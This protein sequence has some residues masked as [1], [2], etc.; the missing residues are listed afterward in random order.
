ME[1]PNN[2]PGE[3]VSDSF[4][5]RPIGYVQSAYAKTK[6]VAHTRNAWTADVSQ[7]KLL[8]KYAKG[9]NG[10]EG[11]SHVIVLFWVHRAEEWKMPEGHGKPPNVKV[12]ATRMPVRPNPMGL[13]VV[14]LVEVSADSGVVVVKGLDALDETPVL[15][16]KP[17]LPTFDSC[18]EACVPQWVERHL[19]S[20]RKSCRECREDDDSRGGK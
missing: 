11:H 20:N 9:L 19:N 7:I 12:F 2:G 16:I 18:P 13:S 5:L 4:E 10:L 1:N 8:P 3:N 14:E 15:D 6:D 17:Y